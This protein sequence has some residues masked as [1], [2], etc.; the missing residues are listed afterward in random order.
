MRRFGTRQHSNFCKPRRHEL[1]STDSRCLYCARPR[2]CSRHIRILA[3]PRAGDNRLNARAMPIRPVV[4]LGASLFTLCALF[5]AVGC[6]LHGERGFFKAF[7]LSPKD[8]GT[9][10][11][12]SNME[13]IV[14]TALEAERFDCDLDMTGEVSR[15]LFDDLACRRDEYILDYR[16][17]DSMAEIRI[18]ARSGNWLG[19]PRRADRDVQ[20]LISSLEAADLKCLEVSPPP[21]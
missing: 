16:V 4:L 7:V 13:W 17:A 2:T 3:T 18:E 19:Q 11:P 6:E 9:E 5:S 12:T 15:I 21:G 8:D 1:R 10:I 14:R 20:R